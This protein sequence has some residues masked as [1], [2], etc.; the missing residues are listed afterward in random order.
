MFD[1]DLQTEVDRKAIAALE[2]VIDDVESGAITP[3]SG[4]RMLAILQTAFNGV[5]SDREFID[6]L[7][8]TDSMFASFPKLTDASFIAYY[9]SEDANCSPEYVVRYRNCRL[10]ISRG[11]RTVKEENYELPSECYRA[12]LKA[13]RHFK[14]KGLYNLCR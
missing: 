12:V 3:E 1:I 14:S 13:H 10:T 4:R 9:K 11:G 6:M 5:T 8:D 2:Q 7:T